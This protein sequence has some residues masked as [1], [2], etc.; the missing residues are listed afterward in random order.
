M[1]HVRVQH[2]VPRDNLNFTVDYNFTV[3]GHDI[4]IAR[5]VGQEVSGIYQQTS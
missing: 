1:I 5:F 4:K 3:S 2:A